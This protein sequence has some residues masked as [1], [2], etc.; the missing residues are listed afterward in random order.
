MTVPL[1]NGSQV[2]GF[3][4]IFP[5][6]ATAQKVIEREMKN[7]D[8]LSNRISHCGAAEMNPPRNH[9]VSGSIPGLAQ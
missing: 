7:Q 4:S 2:P 3:M 1:R 9:E 6:Q 5:L 8:S